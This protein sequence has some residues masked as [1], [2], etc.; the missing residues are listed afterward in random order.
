MAVKS[1]GGI[2]TELLAVTVVRELPGSTREGCRVP[3][4]L[5]RLREEEVQ[6]P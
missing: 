6:W 1:T 5:S 2:E 3:E 4:V